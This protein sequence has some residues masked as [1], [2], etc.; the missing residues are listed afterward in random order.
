MVKAIV[1]GN[2]GDINALIQGN[3]RPQGNEIIDA[4]WTIGPLHCG[5]RVQVPCAGSTGT[6]NFQWAK[7]KIMTGQNQGAG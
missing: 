6:G 7:N 4:I 5:Q 2:F 3:Q 1:R